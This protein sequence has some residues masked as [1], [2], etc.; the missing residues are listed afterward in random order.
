MSSYRNF[1]ILRYKLIFRNTGNST[2]GLAILIFIISFIA[3]VDGYQI[4]L[5][6]FSTA[7]LTFLIGEF[8]RIIS[9]GERK[10]EL[11]LQ[12]ATV[13]VFL[14]WTL[15][16]FLSSLP[17]IFAGFLN[18]S[19]AI[20][21]STSGWTG[22]GLTMFSEVENLPRA[23]LLW[24]SITQYV[25]GAGF[26]TITLI[27]AGSV[28]AGIYQAEGRTD[29][30]VPNLRESAKIILRIYLSWAII[31]IILLMTIGKLSFFDALNH[32]LT[33]LATG[34]FSTK[35][36]SIGSY[37]SLSVHIIIMLLMIMGATGFGV[38]YAALL[39]FKN[40]FRYRKELKKG[41][42]TKFEFKEKI[43]S[44]P[45]LKNPEPKVMFIILTI[46]SILLFLFSLLEIYGVK[47][48]IINSIFQSISS[49]TGTGF[50]TVSFTKWNSFCLLLITLLMIFG[51]MMDST[52]SGLKLFRIY[53][54]FELVFNQIKS[55]FKPSG[56][57]F[58]L[59]VYKG[60]SRKKIDLDAIKNVVVVTTAY[61]VTYFVGVFIL[62]GYGYALPDV[63]FEFAS[64]LSNV[65]LSIGITS[66]QAP[67]GVI[68]TQIIAMYLGRLEFF[69]IINS[70]I[71]I[72]RDLKEIVA[73]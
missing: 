55:F 58:Y 7:I 66:A 36:L 46:F 24:R 51:G 31:G 4:F 6:F 52:S 69:V 13:T 60:I 27:I 3:L 43:R 16:I 53:I 37:S 50:S 8:F 35:N 67:L 45:F 5:A 22:T 48:G 68:W 17:F 72:L 39:M 19:Q 57:T 28:G 42:I 63:L 62:L 14:V 47:D 12:D 21:E 61:F 71:K 26:A 23:I 65:G 38:H 54:A 18:L 10:K 70:F 29:N 15:A 49:L 33:A 44:E 40:F 56:T 41:E 73:P 34:G 25:G 20:F 9:R 1:L 30:L 32:S 59:E 64:T 11:N 2:I